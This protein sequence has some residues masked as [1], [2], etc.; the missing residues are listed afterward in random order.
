MTNRKPYVRKMPRTW[1]LKDPFY[2]VY[3]LR[4][5]TVLPLIFFTMCLLAG[6]ASLAKDA[7]AWEK[8]LTFMSHPV[9]IL[10]NLLALAG[11]LFHAWTFFSM[12]PRVV[13]IRIKG[14]LV[15]KN[16][17]ILSQWAAVAVIS[18]LALVIV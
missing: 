1:W 15:D 5:A 3:M 18:I 6:L 2:R 9:V 12:M 11:S 10:I 13:P 14:K 16:I 17:I 4:E 8:W 7:Y